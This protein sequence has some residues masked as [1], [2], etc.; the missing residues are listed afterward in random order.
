MKGLL[1]NT[2]LVYVYIVRYK[3]L[4]HI[5]N[6][7]PMQGANPYHTS[8]P[9]LWGKFGYI[10]KYD[11]HGVQGLLPSISCAI[12][13]YMHKNILHLAWQ[14]AISARMVV[15]SNAKNLSDRIEK[16]E[17]DLNEYDNAILSNLKK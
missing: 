6:D 10:G 15:E 17:N 3:R 4:P 7:N 13:K 9:S 2:I 14:L 5:Q 11:A 16:L 12:Q 1:N 8:L